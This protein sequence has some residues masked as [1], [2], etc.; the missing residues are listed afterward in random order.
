MLACADGP[1]EGPPQ[2]GPGQGPLV[3]VTLDTT[4][5]DRLG[6]Y[7]H[8]PARTPHLDGLAARGTRFSRAVAPVPLTIP[9]HASLWTGLYPGH[10][11]VHDNGD[12]RLAPEASTL[13]ERLQARGWRT[14]AVV[15]AWVT[16]P[17]WG[18]DQGFDHYDAQLGVPSDRLGWRVERPAA[19]VVDGALAA[20][21]AGTDLL[22]VHLFDAHAPYTPPPP[23]DTLADPYDGEL[24]TL[25]AELGRLFSALPATA[26]VIVAGDHGEGLGEGGERE[27]GL[28][29]TPG[30]LDVPLI[31]AGPGVAVAVDDRPVSVVDVLPTVLRLAGLP[32]DPTLDGQDLLRPTPRPGVLS[33]ARY[34][35]VHYGWAP[36]RAVSTADGRLVRGARDEVEGRV[37]ADA[38][39]LLEAAEGWR[40]AWAPAP[41]TLD[42]SELEQLAALGY[43]ALPARQE[44][45]LDPRDGIHT[46]E[47]LEAAP[48]DATTE[49][50]LRELLAA[51]PR[52][53]ALRLRL[54]TLLLRE[55]RLDEALAEVTTAHRGGPTSTSATVAGDLW[56]Q[57]GDPAEAAGWY[58]EA[59]ALDPLAAA[60]QAGLVSSLAALGHLDE[61]ALLADQAL[62]R[63]PDDARLVLAR[64]ELAVAGGEDPGPHLP[65]IEALVALRP[66]LPRVHQ[67]A[68]ALHRAAGDDES[69][70]ARLLEELRWR[71]ENVGARLELAALLAS[72]G[73]HLSVVKALRPL[74]ASQ[75]EEPLWQ[76]LT[77]QAW[78]ALGR[79]DRAAPHLRACAGHPRCPPGDRAGAPQ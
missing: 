33:E 61:A 59:L 51:Q 38:I 3:I 57:R 7:G 13:A 63:S 17:R 62:G 26:L 70:E 60:A 56:L 1:A 35:A 22:W 54:A 66:W 27:H 76:A 2:L 50:R 42:R 47:A 44:A 43:V 49:A 23:H 4:R 78:L 55:G 67:V 45:G 68:A 5:A 75:P 12:Q 20:L 11:G 19:E 77:A 25:D 69:A 34:G 46:L 21:A 24:A 28:L 36:L 31:V 53:H 10:H 73:R 37:G 39:A 41:L 32:P 14:S 48:L 18:F 79:P 64:A 8:G 30:A 65:R 15:G 74:V 40:P 72:Q 16:A 71:P 58:R 6:S 29:L 9:S 52:M